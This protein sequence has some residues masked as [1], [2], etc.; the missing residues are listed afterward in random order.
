MTFTELQTEFFARG[1]NDLNDA[2]AG[3]VRAKAWINDAYQELC[4]LH[5]W[6]FLETTSTGASPLTISDLGRVI[7]V[8]DSTN[9]YV[10]VYKDR[11]DLYTGD[12]ALDDTGNPS[13][14]YTDNLTIVRTYPAT[15]VSL[16]VRYYKIPATLSSGGDTPVI[17]ARFND[18]IVDGAAVRAYKNKDNFEAAQFVRDEW[19]RGVERMRSVLLHPHY[20]YTDTISVRNADV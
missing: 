13:Y 19:E 14:W 15:S 7:T 17:P 10:L 20:D 11:H 6:P 3:L 1:F 9:D 12:P 16:A 2:G 8:Y 4:D 18:L 5:L